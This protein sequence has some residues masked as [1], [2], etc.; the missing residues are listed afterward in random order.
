ML[1]TQE[2]PFWPSRAQLSVIPLPWSVTLQ[3]AEQLAQRIGGKRSNRETTT[4]YGPNPWPIHHPPGFSVNILT[5]NICE[6]LKPTSA[7]KTKV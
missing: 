6:L 7:G 4:P 2:G 5:G 1:L 3:Q